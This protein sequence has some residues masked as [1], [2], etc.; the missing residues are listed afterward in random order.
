MKHG[1]ICNAYWLLFKQYRSMKQGDVQWKDA[2]KKFDEVFSSYSG[3]EYEPFASKM[4]LAFLGEVERLS[5]C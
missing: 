1:D 2:V 4:H 5:K 3:T